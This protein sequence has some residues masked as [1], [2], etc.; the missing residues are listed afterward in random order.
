MKP[1]FSF[2]K[3]SPNF[4][5]FLLLCVFFIIGFLS[6]LDKSATYDEARNFNYGRSILNGDSNRPGDI[7]VLDGVRI[8]GS[9]MAISAINAIPNKIGSTLANNTGIKSLLES[10]LTARLITI[11]FSTLV[12]L[13]I[14]HWS[15]SL[16]GVIPAVFSLL[17]YIF[18]PN[19]IAHSQLVTTDM[20]AWA[21]TLLVFFCSWKFAKERSLKNG[22]IWAVSLGFSSLAKYTTVILIPL[23]LLAILIYDIPLIQKG[24]KENKRNTI[25]LYFVQ[26]HLEEQSLKI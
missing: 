1:K 21:T 13:L 5:V 9:M 19:I 24:F 22:I 3:L 16:Y 18:D 23:S 25:Q 20:Y 4:I 14:Y 12:A 26:G 7:S 8:D 11:F 15:R 10:I 17:L 2:S 6:V